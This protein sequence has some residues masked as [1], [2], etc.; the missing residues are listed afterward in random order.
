MP[1]PIAD[2][3]AHAAPA[4]PLAL[5]DIEEDAM[6]DVVSDEENVL[7]LV[8]VPSKHMQ[9]LNMQAPPTPHHTTHPSPTNP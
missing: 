5:R 7:S 1:L 9:K 3:D 6:R 4:A 2:R 8:V